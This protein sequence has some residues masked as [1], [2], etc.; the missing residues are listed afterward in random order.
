MALG[1]P[2]C[3]WSRK[4]TRNNPVCSSDHVPAE[5]SMGRV[6]GAVHAPQRPS[7]CPF[8]SCLAWVLQVPGPI[9]GGGPGLRSS[10]PVCGV[11][12]KLWF[13]PF[14]RSGSLSSLP[15]CENLDLGF[16]WCF[17]FPSEAGMSGWGRETP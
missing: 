8:L 5:G 3:A 14:S 4:W 17:S 11:I 12:R 6:Q 1:G 15:A 16:R 10:L 9:L 13:L 7:S 2:L